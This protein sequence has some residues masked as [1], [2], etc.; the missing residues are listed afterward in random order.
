[1]EV[2]SSEDSRRK[3]I[4]ITSWISSMDGRSFSLRMDFHQSINWI[5]SPRDLIGHAPI[6]GTHPLILCLNGKMM[7][8]IAFKCKSSIKV[9]QSRNKNSNKPF[10]MMV[11]LDCP[12]KTG[13]L[14]QEVRKRSGGT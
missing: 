1:M 6:T 2:G 12:E 4:T 3:V 9:K 5:S 10:L 11:L 7:K 8:E 14:F 13:F